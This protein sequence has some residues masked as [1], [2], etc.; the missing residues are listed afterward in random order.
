MLADRIDKQRGAS[1]ENDFAEATKTAVINK[2][3]RGIGKIRKK[4][5]PAPNG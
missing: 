5:I 2:R 4:I 3:A 1:G